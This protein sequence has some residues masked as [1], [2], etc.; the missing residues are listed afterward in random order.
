MM[1]DMWK[2]LAPMERQGGLISMVMGSALA[3]TG[4]VAMMAAVRVVVRAVPVAFV[5]N[6]S[7]IVMALPWKHHPLEEHSAIS[8]R[9]GTKCSHNACG[10]EIR[11]ELNWKLANNPVLAEVRVVRGVRFPF[12]IGWGFH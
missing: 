8:M 1:R 4:N 12:S 7:A 10:P 6:L 11:R 2:V 3:W 9:S 5:M